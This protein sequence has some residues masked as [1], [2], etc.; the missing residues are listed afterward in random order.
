M[1]EIQSLS[2]GTKGT[3][4]VGRR[5][6]TP[7]PKGDPKAGLEEPGLAGRTIHDTVDISGDGAKAVNLSRGRELASEFRSKSADRDFATDL[8][9]ALEDIMR[10]T[11]L[12]RESIKA[13]FKTG[14]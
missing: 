6:P 2:S 3:S 9:K 7:L 13:A 1:V 14:I 8:R 5:A 10:I 12:F 11:R 4:T